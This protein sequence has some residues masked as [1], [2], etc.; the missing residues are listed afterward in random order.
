MGSLTNE[1]MCLVTAREEAFHT[2]EIIKRQYR[3]YE[4]Y[5][6]ISS[7]AEGGR[8]SGAGRRHTGSAGRIVVIDAFGNGRRMVH[9]V[10]LRSWLTIC[11]GAA[12]KAEQ[13]VRMNGQVINGQ[14]Y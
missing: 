1:G 13:L 10:T 6:I 14:C 12:C 11:I 9:G 8:N 5:W 7:Q 4:I 2:N 3:L